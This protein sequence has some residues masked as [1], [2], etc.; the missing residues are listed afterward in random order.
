[1]RSVHYTRMQHEIIAMNEKGV[2]SHKVKNNTF[3]L[4]ELL[5]EYTTCVYPP[6]PPPPQKKKKLFLKHKTKEKRKLINTQTQNK[7]KALHK[8]QHKGKEIQIDTQTNKN[9]HINK[10]RTTPIGTIE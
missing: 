9:S 4:F 1:M 8:N 2:C 3:Y 10:L 5:H 7:S 6:R